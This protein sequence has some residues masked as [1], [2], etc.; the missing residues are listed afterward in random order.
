[1]INEFRQDLVSGEWVLFA[2]GRSKRPGEA[3]AAGD[4]HNPLESQT[5][6]KCPFEDPETSGNQVMATFKT[7][8]G[9]DWFAK[10]IKNKYPAVSEGEAG[11]RRKIG[12]YDVTDAKGLHEIIIFR[13]HDHELY[14]YSQAEFEEVIKIYQDRF[15]AMSQYSASKYI[16]IFHN[17]GPAAGATIKHP[18]SQIISIPILPPDV[19]RSVLGSEHYYRENRRR[20]YDV[21]L[22]WEMKEKKRIIYENEIFAACCPFV[23]KTPYEIRIY[24]KESHAH[25]EKIPQEK[26]PALAD[27][28]KVV[29]G[30]I[31]KALNRPDFNY[32][33]HTVP[34]DNTVEDVH[35]FYSWHIEILPKMKIEGAFEIGSGV[36][37]NV[38]DPDEAAALLRGADVND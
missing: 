38:I 28:M 7:S 37:V 31:G 20:V 4:N 6:D 21:M 26:I 29:I 12:P 27:I 19:K 15:T 23:S 14:D 10:S 11:P 30:K 24:G 34:L 33:I 36:E 25:F 1:M 16:L 13:D 9:D 35:E 17:H 22:E 18:H 3:G 32:F 5:K 2:T 8:D